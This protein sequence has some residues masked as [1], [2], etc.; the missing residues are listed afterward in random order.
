MAQKSGFW[1]APDIGDG[2]A[3]YTRTDLMWAVMVMAACHA[4]EGIAPDF[5]GE[6]AGSVPGANTFRVAA[7]GSIVDGKWHYSDTTEDITIP[8][9]VGGGNTRIDRIVLRADW[10]AQTVRITKLAGVDAS[11]PTAPAITQTNGTTWDILLFQVLVDTAGTVS[12]A[13]DERVWARVGTDGLGNLAVTS[14]KLAADAVIAGK[15][16]DGAV[17]AT[18]ILVDEVVTAAK[19]AN[20]TRRFLVE[21]LRQTV[22]VGAGF[23]FLVYGGVAENN[24]ETT[25]FGYFAVPNDFVSGMTVK[26]VVIAQGASGNLYGLQNATYGA[27]G[28]AYNTHTV[29]GSLAAVALT[30]DQRKTVYSM[31]L[32]D[33]AVGDLVAVEFFR[34]GNDALD[35]VSADVYLMGFLVEYT[36]DS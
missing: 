24:Q 30:S 16:A 32:T 18:A 17:D 31:S 36:A 4:F 33:A 7:G 3:K 35:T 21:P 20:R 12:L 13:V 10:S 22:P 5:L 15:I 23:P 28:E 6:F 27:D 25:L 19:I 1:T 11:S 26:A 34:D 9:A 8:S 2:V 29:S 14:G